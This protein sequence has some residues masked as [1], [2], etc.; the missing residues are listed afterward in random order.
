[1]TLKRLTRSRLA[2]DFTGWEHDNA[3][4]EH[5]FEKLFRALRID[6]GPQQF[7]GEVMAHNR[8]ET[9]NLFERLRL[10]L[11]Q[12]LGELARG[13]LWVVAHA[14][15]VAMK[16]SGVTPGSTDAWLMTSA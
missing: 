7:L 6:E 3:K 14:C 11:A 13:Q 1:M 8:D 12:R 4:F 15:I 2:A 16:R 10:R 9:A 5:E